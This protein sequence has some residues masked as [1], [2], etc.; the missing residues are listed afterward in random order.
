MKLLP[1]LALLLA[2]CGYSRAWSEPRI[3]ALSDE[4]LITAHQVAAE[5]LTAATVPL[6]RELT[7]AEMKRRG[8]LGPGR[9]GIP[10]KEGQP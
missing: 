2:G 1:L 4:D 9:D 5:P 10:A 7:T 3:R 6:Q 8:L